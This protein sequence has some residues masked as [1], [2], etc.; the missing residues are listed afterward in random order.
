MQRPAA[1]AFEAELVILSRKPAGFAKTLNWIVAYGQGAET[2]NGPPLDLGDT[3]I[4]LLVNAKTHRMDFA[5][6]F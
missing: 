6:H 2:G 5:G 4:N 1:S 3:A